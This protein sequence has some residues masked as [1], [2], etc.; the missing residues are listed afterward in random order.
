VVKEQKN[1][2]IIENDLDLVEAM[3]LTLGSAGYHVEAA[4][5]PEAGFMKAKTNP[6]DLIILDVLFGNGGQASGFD[7]LVKFKQDKPLASIPIIMVSASTGHYSGLD[8]GPIIQGESL[9]VDAFLNKPIDP[10]DLVR[11]AEKLLRKGVSK[12]TNWP[13]K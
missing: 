3:K 12:W 9:P 5:H 8:F 6:P 10:D 11:R 2:L 7:Y 1:I 13:D 4:Y